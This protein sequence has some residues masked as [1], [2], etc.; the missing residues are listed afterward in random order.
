MPRIRVES[1]NRVTSNS[2]RSVIHA[3][4]PL[5]KDV[6]T[7][8]EGIFDTLIK[9]TIP[10]AIRNAIKGGVSYRMGSWIR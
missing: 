1:N 4:V 10:P 7:S 2:S 5:Y 9:P 8:F 6:T 3:D